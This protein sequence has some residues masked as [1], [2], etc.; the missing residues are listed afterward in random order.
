MLQF[1]LGMVM[2][3]FWQVGL[4]KLVCAYLV[5]FS[6]IAT[7]ASNGIPKNSKFW[8]PKFFKSQWG[9]RSVYSSSGQ[10]LVGTKVNLI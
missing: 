8:K 1:V 10:D 3:A 6:Y 4:L 2:S 9:A 5:T 7:N